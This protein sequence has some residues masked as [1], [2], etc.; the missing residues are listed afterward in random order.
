MGSGE[1]RTAPKVEG[2]GVCPITGAFAVAQNFLNKIVI[3]KVPNKIAAFF[4]VRVVC[5][6]CG[7]LY[8]MVF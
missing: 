5:K 4:A 2:I 1:I 3:E 8:S 7:N 6:E